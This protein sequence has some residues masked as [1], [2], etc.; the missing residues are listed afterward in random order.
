MSENLDFN[1]NISK[2]S[3]DPA[4]DVATKK[5]EKLEGVLET[6]V[7]V[8]AGNLLTKAFDSIVGGIGSLIDF[9]N[10][11]IDA[12]AGQEVAVNNL[13]AA[14][15]RAGNYSAEA[16]LGLQKFAGALQSTTVFED[17][18]IEGATALLQSITKLNVEG[19]EKGVTAA[20][21]FATVLKVDL[22]TATRLVAK[23]ANGNANAFAKYGLAVEAGATNS[24]TFSRVLEKINSQLG[25]AANSQLNTYSGSLKG[26]KVAYGDLLEPI[27]EIIVKN[28]TV[29]GTFNAIKD[30]LND[31]NSAVSSNNGALKELVSDGIFFA[32]SA[33]ETLFDALDGIVR[34]G[35]VLVNSF[36]LIGDAI[37]FGVIGAFR[38]AFD[39]VL[40]FLKALPLVGKAF[41]DIQNPITGLSDS[42]SNKL[43]K[44]FED[45]RKAAG[46]NL[47][48]TLSDESAKFGD[49]V[50]SASEKAALANSNIVNGKKGTLTVE[51]ET[52]AAI[53]ASRQQLNNDILALSIQ[54]QADQDTLNAQI[55]ASTLEEGYAKNEQ[56]ISDLYDQKVREAEVAYQGELL[57]NEA[58]TNAENQRLA[59]RVATIKRDQAIEKAALDQRVAQNKISNDSIAAYDKFSTQQKLNIAGQGFSALADIAKQG[60]KEQFFL[61][62]AAAA[63]Q[64]AMAWAV[65]QANALLVPPPM[66]PA[67]L[68]FANVTAGIAAASLA[69]ATIKGY[70]DGGIVGQGASRGSDNRI[71]T[72]RDGEMILNADQQKTVF[73]ML[74]GGGVGGD[75]IVQID[76]R[77]VARAV[78][79]QVQGGF[80]LA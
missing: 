53:L 60:S 33:A 8:F 17:D 25:G 52:N 73:D 75:I 77:E 27:G 31:L 44:S 12:A 70:A 64:I 39:V 74:N 28:P 48:T 38:V 18:A 32:I 42:L 20:A 5:A 15:A 68:A 54:G 13:N 43:S 55:A 59:N 16:S 24:E 45:V 19:L 41:T 47:F 62:K 34:V 11:A 35:G 46:D 23:A 9:T 69:A 63:A 80:R 66:Q 26:L 6:A 40:E 49:A 72:V 50:V 76:G 67:A 29:V 78:R 3:L 65:G 2:N 51:D 57:K 21:D 58:I 71:A 36:F 10:E 22:E 61:Q 4:L 7:S 37:S 30:V 14:L 56:V 1:L 79:N